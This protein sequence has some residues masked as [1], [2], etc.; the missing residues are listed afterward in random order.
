MK[1]SFYYGIR[2]LSGYPRLTFPYGEGGWI[3]VDERDSIGH[4]IL[5]RGHYEPEVWEKLAAFA[6]SR[7]VVW[8][9]GSHIG[10]FAIRAG[11]DP[12]VKEVHSFE[13]DP[14]SRAVLVSNLILNRGQHITHP[15]ALSDKREIRKLF[16]GPSYN[17][18]LS[19]LF[20]EVS[21]ETV[22]VDCKTADELVFEDKIN[23][24]TL[25]KID[26]EGWERQ[27]LKGSQR[28]LKEIPPK[29][30]IFESECKQSGEISTPVLTNLLESLGFRV[31]RIQR[32]SG[33]IEP[34]ENFLAVRK[35][36]P[37]SQVS[38]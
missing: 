25:M 29:A 13:P 18:G 28:L 11:L 38:K 7:E 12:R 16:L 3:T 8:D 36:Q 14:G 1:L 35:T 37:S 10:S 9:I 21:E 2:R 20:L 4:E 27:V 24:P 22:Q 19:S 34:R 23:P 15:V 6:D 26:V 33:L 17:G 5:A 32:P 31:T 30:I